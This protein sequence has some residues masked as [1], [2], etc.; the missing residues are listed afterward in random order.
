MVPNKRLR[1]KDQRL[2]SRSHTL[3]MWGSKLELGYL[4]PASPKITRFCIGKH[5][6]TM[7]PVSLL[8]LAGGFE[9]N[10]VLVGSCIH[11]KLA[12]WRYPPSTY[13]SLGGSKNWRRGRKG[14]AKRNCS[15]KLHGIRSNPNIRSTIPWE[16]TLGKIC[17]GTRGGLLNLKRNTALLA[18]SNKYT[19][20]K[21]QLILKWLVITNLKNRDPCVKC[22]RVTVW[23]N[24]PKSVG[25]LN[26]TDNQ[27]SS[28][29]TK[30][31]EGS[32]KLWKLSLSESLNHGSGDNA[33]NKGSFLM[34]VQQCFWSLI[35][36]LAVQDPSTILNCRHL[37]GAACSRI[38]QFLLTIWACSNPR[39]VDPALVW[40]TTSFTTEAAEF[41][42]WDRG[43]VNIGESKS[44]QNTKDFK[45][46]WYIKDATLHVGT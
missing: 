25:P 14:V 44:V 36:G 16:K 30:E 3:G 5:Q 28:T 31:V 41:S 18:E 20:W 32:L 17:T 10:P 6:P 4:V 7:T 15:G 46:S 45:R 40:S 26:R 38:S 22:K 13:P 12:L 29:K 1:V 9:G 34:N 35:V 33:L 24:V 21:N 37:L 42:S 8:V 2:S 39:H 11:P 27:S 19:P 43:K 23:N